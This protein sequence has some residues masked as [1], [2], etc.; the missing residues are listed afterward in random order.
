MPSRRLLIV[1]ICLAAATHEGWA[2]EAPPLPLK[3][4]GNM[5]AGKGGRPPRGEPLH[6]EADRIQ[7][8]PDGEVVAEGQVALRRADQLVN[9]AWLR[10]DRPVDTV[11]ARGGVVF[12]TGE[13]RIS[14]SELR[15]KV[16]ERLGD[17]REVDYQFQTRLGL[18]ARGQADTIHFEGPDRYRMESATYS[19]CP[20]NQ[21][22]WV[23]RSE[24]LKLDYGTSLGS[25][26]RVKVEYLGTP[27]LYAPWM[28]FSLD[29]QRKSG[30]LTPAYG[31]SDLR[32]IELMAPWY[33]NIAP[34]RD[35]TLT[36][37]LMT[38]RGLQLM[39]EYRYL[40]PDYQ[41]EVILELL[42][43]D[44]V[45]NETRARAAVSHQHRFTPRLSG[46]LQLENVS[47]D[48]YFTDLFS[49]STLTS[50]V[51]LPREAGLTYVGEGWRVSGRV[52]TYQTLQDP[53]AP[54]VPPYYRVPQIT[55]S[56]Q[57][58]D[59]PLDGLDLDVNGEFVRYD[60]ET[61]Q[62]VQG[63]RLHLNP[64]LG[65][66]WQSSYASLTP[67]LGWYL[68]RYDL[69][70]S[71]VNLADSL[72]TPGVNC[73]TFTSQTR[74]L[75]MFSLDSQVFMERDWSW[76]GRNFIQTLEPRA[77][78]VF[79]PNETQSDIPVFDS[80]IADLSLFQL[81]SENQFTSVD[82]VNNANQLTLAVTSRLLEPAS[83]AERLQVTVGQRY[84]FSDQKVT[85]PGG[86][87]RGG[88]S[89]DLLAQVSSQINRRV[90]I[91]SG[92]Q[93]NTDDGET[94]KANL[95]YTYRDGPGKVFNADYRFT[96][97]KY[98]ASA[99]VDQLDIS[100][101]WP[102]KPQWYGLGR[103]N[104]SFQESRLVEGLVGF[105]YNPGCWSLRGVVQRLA[106]SE[107]DSSNAFFLQLELRGLT[108][109]GPNPL[110]ILKRSISGYAKSDEFD[111]P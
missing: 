4:T 35:A 84:Y 26:R 19:T 95:G 49:S 60:H 102:L 42:P 93:F 65:Y 88:N 69:D 67:R 54:I 27:L 90:R 71:S 75:P 46:S 56:G 100:W 104:Y 76:H 74:S 44:R 77:Y 63:S 96:N 52:Q 15:L 108:K 20:A 66:T 16:T 97:D 110:E 51:N 12:T 99:G 34:N 107:T 64:S 109:L 40:Q 23:L 38:R 86:T 30:F 111:L 98:A 80:G 32:G 5:A 94:V 92:I 7:G 6:L 70:E 14:G 85:L 59:V 58:R 103:V 61:N 37:R 9:A 28:D 21:Q 10:Y 48:T 89:T 47:D 87:V 53:L 13:R 25:A 31:V 1:P 18:T 29:E 79:I 68:T 50:R 22:D 82:R 78:Y 3:P 72:C 45:K 33:W 41:G 36:P 2:V 24:E 57:R 91:Q 17:M 81:F 43:G 55:F 83:G 11:E 62:R 106:T 101:Q 39:G 8:V 105:E 73:P